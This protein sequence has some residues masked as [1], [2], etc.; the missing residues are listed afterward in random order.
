[1]GVSKEQVESSLTAKLSPSHLE[2]VDVSAGCGAK[3]TVEIV[4]E[5]FEGKRLL[6]RHR[7]VNAA[8]AEELKEIHALSITKAVTPSQWEQQ[9]ASEKTQAAA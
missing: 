4:S 2:V 1:M 5:Q 3:F 9:Q 6:E 8:L 7:M